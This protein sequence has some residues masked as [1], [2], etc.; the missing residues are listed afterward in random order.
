[1]IG[2]TGETEISGRRFG[3]LAIVA[4]LV[5]GSL[6]ARLWFLQVVTPEAAV[7]TATSNREREI[8]VEAPRGRILDAEGRVLAG[9]RESLVVFS[10]CLCVSQFVDRLVYF[11]SGS[12]HFCVERLLLFCRQFWR[13]FAFFRRHWGGDVRGGNCLMDLLNFRVWDVVGCN[14]QDRNAE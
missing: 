1:M 9:R 13:S 12:L 6:T 4:L 14:Q 10:R 3:A 2:D 8:W 7:E 11:K 5:F